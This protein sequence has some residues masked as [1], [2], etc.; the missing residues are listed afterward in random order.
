[1]GEDVV[2]LFFELLPVCLG[3]ADGGDMHVES[4]SRHTM[5]EQELDPREWPQGQHHETEN[6]LRR[7]QTGRPPFLRQVAKNVSQLTEEMHAIPDGADL[8]ALL[9]EELPHFCMSEPLD[10]PRVAFFQV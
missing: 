8:K 7:Q 9:R 3:R 5:E 10:M 1:L 6:P 4:G 2:H